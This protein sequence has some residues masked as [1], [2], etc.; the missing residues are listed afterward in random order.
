MKRAVGINLNHNKLKVS[1]VD[2]NGSYHIQNF[3]ELDLKILDFYGNLSL[4]EE[5]EVTKISALL[6]NNFQAARL[7]EMEASITI[8]DQVC[9]LQII[10]LP[11][12]SE[13]EIVSAIELQ[14]EEFVPYPIEKASFD[15]QILSTNQQEKQMSVLVVVSLKDMINRVADFVL[16]LG[17]YPATLEPESTAVFRYLS[18]NMYNSPDQLVLF[19]N[20]GNQ[21]TQA[22]IMNVKQKQLVTTHSFNIG[23][24]F[25][26]KALHNNLNI[27]LVE[28]VNLFAKLKK[29]N[30]EYQKILSPVFQE[31]DKEIQK[32]L[33]MAMARLSVPVKNILISAENGIDTFVSLFKDAL[34]QAGYNIQRLSFAQVSPK[35]LNLNAGVDKTKLD[36]YITSIAAV[37]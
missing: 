27:N 1:V 30:S 9:S 15:Y 14:A 37:I 13:K 20:I 28:A 35:Q 23:L 11:L 17:L 7:M 4:E 22:S 6:K 25:F 31:Y 26:T 19:M 2:V 34:G 21:S 24:N 10:K 32:I 36:N 18:G 12:V 5:K 33:A 3:F 29:E 8:P 16:E